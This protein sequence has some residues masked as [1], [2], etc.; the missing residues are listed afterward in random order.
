MRRVSTRLSGKIESNRAQ[1][2]SWSSLRGRSSR[3]AGMDPRAGTCLPASHRES[4]RASRCQGH[5]RSPRPGH[6]RSRTPTIEGHVQLEAPTGRSC[7]GFH[8]AAEHEAGIR[9]APRILGLEA[10]AEPTS[11][12]GTS[13]PAGIRP[14]GVQIRSPPSAGRITLNLGVPNRGIVV[15]AV[16]PVGH[17]VAIVVGDDAIRDPCSAGSTTAGSRRV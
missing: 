8:G 10:G 5:S 12:S 17:A 15:D 2:N 3:D 13:I 7:G 6:S 9:S 16:S 14:T 11:R 4:R 1:S